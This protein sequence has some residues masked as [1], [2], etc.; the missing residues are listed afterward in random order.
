[1]AKPSYLFPST[2]FNNHFHY[3]QQDGTAKGDLSGVAEGEDGSLGPNS[4]KKNIYGGKIDCP[5]TGKGK[6]INRMGDPLLYLN[7]IIYGKV[8][9]YRKT[10]MATAL[11]SLKPGP[12][13]GDGGIP[14]FLFIP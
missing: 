2:S 6:P 13:A 9:I 4:F 1:M 12:R 3:R 14:V 5:A 11:P 7:R 8:P 10:A